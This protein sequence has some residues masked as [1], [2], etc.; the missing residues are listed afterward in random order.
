MLL[1]LFFR[2]ERRLRLGITRSQWL[3]DQ[4]HRQFIA[5]IDSHGAN[6]LRRGEHHDL[7]S[8]PM[9]EVVAVMPF[10]AANEGVGHSD[11][12]LRRRYLLATFWP[13]RDIF[14]HIVI[15]VCEK[16]DLEFVR[17]AGLPVYD[18]FY[19]PVPDPRKLGVATLFRVNRALNGNLAAAGSTF[20]G[21]SGWHEFKFIYYTESDQILRIR[22]LSFWL[23]L[24]AR[25]N[26]IVVP[27]RAAPV[28]RF[29][30]FQDGPLEIRTNI[31]SFWGKEAP[32]TRDELDGNG[33]NRLSILQ[34]PRNDRCCF[35]SEEHACRNKH[36]LQSN[37][38]DLTLI[39]FSSSTS[40][41]E[42]SASSFAIIAGEG[43]FWKM[44][45]R[46][47]DVHLASDSNKRC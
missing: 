34:N 14:P 30:D 40:D 44:R 41:P 23:A 45:F 31:S 16:S 9:P 26:Y 29:N 13:L 35:P 22:H 4:M 33:R 24:A 2:Y 19:A 20:R 6:L 3:K 25:P 38:S 8:R 36:H 27:H 12:D 47:C 7:G 10:F 17:S 5:R 15:S 11:V 37:A 32:L 46:R 42:P 39:Q 43:N 1:G 21:T 18:V 28:P